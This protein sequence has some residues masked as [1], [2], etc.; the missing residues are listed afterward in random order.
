MNHKDSLLT[1]EIA[2]TQLHSRLFLGTANYPSP[3]ILIQALEAA[4]AEVITVSLRRIDPEHPEQSILGFL[5]LSQYHLLPNTAGC[6]TAKEAILTAKVAREALGTNWIKVEVIADE[7]TL[8][9][10]PIG[11]VKACEELVKDGFQVFPYC[12]DDPILC[13]RLEEIGCAAIMPL[14]APIGTGLGIRN[15]HNLELI[16]DLVSI[17]VIVDAGIGTA[18]DVAQAFE[19]GCDAVLINTAIAEAIN[20]V[21]MAKACYHASIAGRAAYLAGRIPK[22]YLAKASSPLTNRI[23]ME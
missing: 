14:A 15:P 6:K 7:R 23:K 1:W 8:L 3:E 21:L 19:L 17:P 13:K 18:S 20:P 16:R 22:R 2:N 9:P 10:D 12:S 5:D 11:L 4:Q